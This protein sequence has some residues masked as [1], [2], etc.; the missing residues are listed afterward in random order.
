[1][2]LNLYKNVK[3]LTDINLAELLKPNFNL[4]SAAFPPE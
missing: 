4:M 3:T 1:M 2:T